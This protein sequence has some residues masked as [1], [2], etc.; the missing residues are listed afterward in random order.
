MAVYLNGVLQYEVSVANTFTADQTFQGKIL[1]SGSGSTFGSLTTTGIYI[2]TN[3]NL[4]ASLAT[5]KAFAI[6]FNGNQF[7]QITSTAGSILGIGSTQQTQIGAAGFS[8]YN[9]I[10][11]VGNGV[12]SIVAS[13]KTGSVSTTQTNAIN[14]TPPAATGTYRMNIFISNTSGTNTGTWT[15]AI[16]YASPGGQTT[17]A[18]NFEQLGTLTY[19]LAPTGASKDF[20]ASFTFGI[21]NSATAITLTLTVTGTVASFINATLEQLA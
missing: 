3:N 9:N 12:P 4:I 10:T 18:P 14:Y 5:G 1:F 13:V 11:T 6:T 17:Y 8:K 7:L 21:D 20:Y 19:I 2:D 16:G 15:P